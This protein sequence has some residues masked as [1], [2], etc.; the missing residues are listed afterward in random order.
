MKPAIRP[1]H[2]DMTHLTTLDEL[3]RHI[4]LLS[5]VEETDASFVSAYIN[6]EHGSMSWRKTLDER[7]RILRRI[8]KGDDL[9]DFEEAVGKIVA[10][11]ALNT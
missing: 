3:K 1:K 7:A 8:L 2:A 5:S 4:A 11:G 9:V 6:L 10:G